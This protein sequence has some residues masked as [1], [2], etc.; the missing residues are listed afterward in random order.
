VARI[1]AQWSV[2]KSSAPG[3]LSLWGKITDGAARVEILDHYAAP[4]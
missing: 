2:I 3:R 1:G 4:E